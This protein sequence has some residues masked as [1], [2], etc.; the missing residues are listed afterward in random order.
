MTNRGNWEPDVVHVPSN[1][2]GMVGAVALAA[3]G[4][5]VGDG[6]TSPVADGVGT[7][8]D[9]GVGSAVTTGMGVGALP[10]AGVIVG[11]AAD[12]QP[13]SSPVTED[14]RSILVWPLACIR[15]LPWTPHRRPHQ[16][17]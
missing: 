4:A 15:L 11:P 8:E 2:A 16:G 14:T 13:M 6:V 3:G 12:E 7:G 9:V 5:G 17:R 1:S 10:V